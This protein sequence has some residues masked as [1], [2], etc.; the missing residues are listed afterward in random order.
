MSFCIIPL[1]VT[2]C[3]NKESLK[4]RVIIKVP[5]KKKYIFIVN[6]LMK[7]HFKLFFSMP[8]SLPETLSYRLPSFLSSYWIWKLQN[9]KKVIINLPILFCSN[10]RE[11]ECVYIEMCKLHRVGMI[12]YIYIPRRVI[13]FIYTLMWKHPLIN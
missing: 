12:Y 2:D 6:I 9:L 5:R 4:Q 3:S 10:Y 8:V 13:F 7:F 1:V 11:D